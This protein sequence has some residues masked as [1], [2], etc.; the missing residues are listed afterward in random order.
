[1][2]CG[3]SFP[4][5]RSLPTQSGAGANV[6]LVAS[7]HEAA[8]IAGRAGDW[9]EQTIRTRF[10][11]LA[12]RLKGGVREPSLRTIGCYGHICRLPIADGALLVGDAAT[13][14]DPFTG[15]GVYFSLRGAQLA[16]ETALQALRRAGSVS[17]P[18][19]A[20]Y[21]RARGELTRRYLLCDLVQSVVRTPYLLNRVVERLRRYPGAADLL[22]GVLGDTRPATAVLHPML[23]WRLIGPAI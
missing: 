11:D 22:L 17:L 5:S 7:T 13:F 23:A 8:Q 18:A 19:L 3:M 16:A 6:T 14:I 20:P 2:V 9:V 4:G 12:D 1:M 10:P 21:A 15:E